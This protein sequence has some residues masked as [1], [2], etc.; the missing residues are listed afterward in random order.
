MGYNYPKNTFLQLKHYIQRIYLTLLPT[1]AKMQRISY[2]I[3][4]NISHFSWHNLSLFFELK[5]YILYTEIPPSNC[6]FS[7]F[8]SLELKFSKLFMPF[9]KQEV[10]FSSK[11]GS[12]FS[13][14]RDNSSALFK[15]KLY[16]LLTKV[17][18]QSANFQTC[19]CPC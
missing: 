5:H 16:I 13:L 4:E 8:L 18:D 3:F 17:A 19:H 6:K 11:F 9:F 15:V 14:L 1:K 12:L 7:D 2:V 10:S